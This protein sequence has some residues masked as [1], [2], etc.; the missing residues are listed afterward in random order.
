MKSYKECCSEVAMKHRLGKSLVTGHRA[1]YWEEAAEMYASELKKENE[2]LKQQ[3]LR[4]R[5]RRLVDKD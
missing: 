4:L 5:P 1:G 2:Q 3:I